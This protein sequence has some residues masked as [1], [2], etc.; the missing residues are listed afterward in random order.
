V[1][2][3]RIRVT[4]LVPGKRVAWRVLENY[5][6]FVEDQREWIGNE[7]VFDIASKGDKTEVVFTQIGLT[8]EYECYELCRNAW[9]GYIKGSLRALIATGKGAPTL[10]A[11]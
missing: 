7:T 5:M 6:S 1:H 9:S 4:E 8:P 11:M 3:S 2:V 10:K